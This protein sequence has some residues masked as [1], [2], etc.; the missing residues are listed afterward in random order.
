ML[1]GPA[2]GGSDSSRCRPRFSARF[3]SLP[4]TG[5]SLSKICPGPPGAFLSPFPVVIGCTAFK[6]SN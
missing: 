3:F 5:C 2:L 1:D 6:L 4:G